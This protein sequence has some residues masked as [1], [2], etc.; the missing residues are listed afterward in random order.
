VVAT[1]STTSTAAGRGTVEGPFAQIEGARCRIHIIDQINDIAGDMRGNP[2]II[3]LPQI[4]RRGEL[5]DPFRHRAATRAVDSTPAALSNRP[6][7]RL[8][9]NQ[10]VNHQ[11]TVETLRLQLL[12][13]PLKAGCSVRVATTTPPRRIFARCMGI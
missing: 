11:L 1:S 2:H 4:N 13:L 6:V 10:R 5:V 9:S 3:A 12:L 8:E 7:L